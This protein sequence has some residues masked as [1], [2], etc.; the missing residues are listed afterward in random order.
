MQSTEISTS[1]WC[2]PKKKNKKKRTKIKKKAVA[3]RTF[4]LDHIFHAVQTKNATLQTKKNS[5]DRLYVYS[6]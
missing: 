4:V 2:A 1:N 6:A 3:K 5:I